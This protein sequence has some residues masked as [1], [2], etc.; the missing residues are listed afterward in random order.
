M[1]CLMMISF[2]SMIAVRL[3]VLFHVNEMSEIAT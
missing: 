2:G 3:I 1:K